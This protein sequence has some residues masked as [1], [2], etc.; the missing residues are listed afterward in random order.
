MK[1]ETKNYYPMANR[2]KSLKSPSQA[3]NKEESRVNINNTKNSGRRKELRIQA[4]SVISLEGDCTI[5]DHKEPM[6]IYPKK[7]KK[8]IGSNSKNNFYIMGTKPRVITH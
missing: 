7:S 3:V 1:L 8:E 6:N 5:Y 2:A 4:K